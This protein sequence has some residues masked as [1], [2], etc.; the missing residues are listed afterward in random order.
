MISNANANANAKDKTRSV[1][2]SNCIGIVS[3]AA[4]SVVTDTEQLDHMCFELS[5]RGGSG[6]TNPQQVIREQCESQGRL[7]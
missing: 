2:L 4:T 3:V 6:E 1:L 5:C 7:R